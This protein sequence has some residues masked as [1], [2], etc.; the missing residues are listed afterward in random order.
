MC[1]GAE[2]PFDFYFFQ[3]AQEESSHA[4]VALDVTEDAFDL[5]GA[6]RAHLQAFFAVE[7]GAGDG[8][9][10][11]ESAV[12]VDFAV[13]VGF[14][15][16]DAFV[17]V[18]AAGAGFALVDADQAFKTVVAALFFLITAACNS[19]SLSHDPLHAPC[20]SQE[21]MSPNLSATTTFDVAHMA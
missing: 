10:G 17:P 11:V 18:R 14:V 5:N 19:C 1:D 6:Q 15:A 2:C 13:G 20:D 12:D 7:V 3:A 16:L 21:S 9:Q 8:F 4:K